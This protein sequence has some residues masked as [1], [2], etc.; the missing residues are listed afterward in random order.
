MIILNEVDDDDEINIKIVT[1]HFE[2]T[3]II[4][5]KI[6]ELTSIFFGQ[7]SA[8]KYCSRTINLYNILPQPKTKQNKTTFLE[9]YYNQ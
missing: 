7:Y 8:S 6:G 9:W 4:T 2:K 5:E 1:L 3:I